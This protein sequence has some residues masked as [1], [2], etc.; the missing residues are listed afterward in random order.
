[1]NKINLQNQFLIAQNTDANNPFHRAVIYICEHTCEGAMGLVINRPTGLN[2]SEVFTSLEIVIDNY[3]MATEPVLAGGPVQENVG[4]V[5]HSEQGSWDSSLSISPEITVTTSQDI[6]QNIAVDNALS[7]QLVILGYSG[8]A[9]NQLEQ[10]I[11]SNAW[12][13][14]PAT[15]DILFSTPLESRWEAA[16]RSLG[17]EPSQLVNVVGHA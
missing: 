6:L 7:N 9:P 17:I 16:I 12:L 2:L 5:I 13:T 3:T 1:M 15:A 8:W 4:F 10:E 11:K 14:C